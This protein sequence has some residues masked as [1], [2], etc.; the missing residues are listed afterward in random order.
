[1]MVGHAML[2]FAAATAVASRRWPTDRALAFGVVAGAFA[3]VPDVDMLYAVFG[4][5]RT[6]LAGVWAMTDAFWTSSNVVHRAVTH[7]LVVGLVAA[8]IFAGSVADRG[9]A[10]AALLGVG[11]VALTAAASGSLGA[12]IVA[13]FLL[14]GVGI[15]QATVRKTDLGPQAVFAAALVGLLTH[16]FGDVFTGAPPRFFYPLD[17]RVLTDRVVL[18]ADPTL[19]LLAVFAVELA[20]IWL[21]GCVY[22]RATDRR[23]LSHVDARAAVGVAYA[24]AAVAMPAPTMQVSYHFVFSILAIAIVGIAPHL[25]PSRPLLS[26]DWHDRITWGMTGLAAVSV[27]ALAY[28]L[29][30]V[31]F[32]T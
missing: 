25:L 5:A 27:A 17:V 15:A 24:I 13:A 30:Y 1:M 31:F 12:A 14:A 29:T 2:A 26:A 28:T 10:V 22:L 11:I 21:A 6:G 20:T 16:P 7:S 9:R 32:S 19:N 8:S 23:L 3:T 18:L 4:L